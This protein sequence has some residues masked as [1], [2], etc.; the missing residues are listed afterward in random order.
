MALDKKI[1][2]LVCDDSI[3]FREFLVRSI[4]MDPN[5]EVVAVAGNPYEARDLILQKHPD[6]MTLD[7]E[8]PRMSGIEFL[9]Q[10]MPQFPM[11]VVVVSTLSDRVFDAMDAGAVD[12]VSKPSGMR[13]QDIENFVRTE[14]NVKIKIASVAKLGNKKRAGFEGGVFRGAGVTYSKRVIAIGASTG[15]TEA[16]YSIIKQFGP[17]IPGVVVVQHMPP[18]FTAMYA[19]RLNNQCTVRVKEA[20]DGDQVLPGQVLIAAGD[21]HMRVVRSGGGYAVSCKV[22]DKVSGHCPSVDVL[23]DSVAQ[24][25]GKSAVGVIC[26]GMGED[27]AR[28]LLAMRTAGA[29]TIGQDA[30]TCVVYGM[31]KVAFERGAVSYQVKLEDIAKKVYSLIR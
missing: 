8:M 14:L 2:V 3:L 13:A 10:L 29:E 4:N 16:V 5:L 7:I 19:N 6:V 31:P 28:G 17:D 30:S 1:K 15:G 9:K 21:K 20:A 18:G 24:A 22:G 26:T 12:F 25:V 27:G 23:F 11:P